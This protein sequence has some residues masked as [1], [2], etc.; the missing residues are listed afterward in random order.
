MPRSTA[1]LRRFSGALA[2]LLLPSFARAHTGGG[3]HTGLRRS[4]P[5]KGSRLSVAPSRIALWFTVRPQLPFSKIRLAGPDGDIP[6]DRLVAD[7]GNGFYARVPRPLPAG[8]YTVHWQTASAD[9]HAIR[10]EFGFAVAE[11][12]GPTQIDPVIA[13]MTHQSNPEA[14]AVQSEYRTA[15]W[16]E[17]VALLTVLGVL[18]FRHGVL[19]P[20]AARGVGTSDAAD[21]ARR[22]GQSALVLYVLA[23]LV[24]LYTESVSIHGDAALAARSLTPMLTGTM[25]GIGWL[26]GVIGA[27][28]L[29]LGWTISK[30]NV[31]IGTPLALTGALGMVLSPAMSGHATSSRY[32][33]LSMTLDMLHVAAAGVWIGGLLLVLLAGIPAMRRLTDGNQDAAISALVSSFH[34]MALF[35]APLV[36]VAGLGTSWIRLGAFANVWGTGYG[37]TLLWKIVLVALVISMGSYNSLRARRRLGSV[38]G[39]GG[40]T[41]V[42]GTRHFRLTASIE[43][44]F[45]ALVLAATT[46]LV[47][48]PVPT[49]MVQP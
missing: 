44:L 16:L 38:E 24:R 15:R 37:R 27:V 21:R 13:P 8:Q 11:A 14:L 6:L 18:G 9:G 17:F 7:T 10:G 25:W 22:L 29:M 19:P 2:L 46:V 5:G 20:L 34:P 28:L 41:G 48:T 23:A 36:V 30:K 47:V 32:F 33:V 40:G 43:L 39:T 49:D 35:C 1:Q 31:M 12:G 4:D 3:F 26:A 45:A 42:K